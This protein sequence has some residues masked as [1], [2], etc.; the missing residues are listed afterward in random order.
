MTRV[1]RS[2]EQAY[3]A[4]GVTPDSS[5]AEIQAAVRK[6]LQANHPD[7]PGGDLEVYFAVNNAKRFLQSLKPC[8]ECGGDKLVKIR[9]GRATITKPCGAC[10]V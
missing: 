10:S 7:R 2:K 5:D 4:I 9:Q 8:S 1:I 6:L 3:A